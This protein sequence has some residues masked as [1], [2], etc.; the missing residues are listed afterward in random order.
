M[1]ELNYHGGLPSSD[2]F[3]RALSQAISTASP[4]DDLLELADRLREFELRYHLPS[5]EFYQ[6]YQAGTLSEEL[7]H[8][9]EW[10]AVYDLSL[11]TRRILEAT[12]MRAAVKPELSEAAA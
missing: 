10:A 6:Q 11:K 9:I 12:L 8:C 1:P 3:H 4:V 7:Q 2:E 5:E